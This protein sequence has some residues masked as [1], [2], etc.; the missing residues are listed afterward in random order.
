LGADHPSDT[1]LLVVGQDNLAGLP[2][3]RD[4][5]RLLS[6]ADLCVFPRDDT[7]DADAVRSLLAEEGLRPRGV[8]VVEDFRVPVSSSRVRAMLAA[9]EDVS[10]LVPAE[11]ADYIAAHGLYAS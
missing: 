8:R 7:L 3:W 11:V 6:L 4:V 10:S 5:D 9:H 2:G 1:L